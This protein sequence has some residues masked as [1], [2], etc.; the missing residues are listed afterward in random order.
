MFNK[1][2]N[3]DINHFSLNDCLS[4]LD[5]SESF[6]LSM[7]SLYYEPNELK[8]AIMTLKIKHKY[9]ALHINIQSLPAT[10]DKLKDLL[11]DLKIA[12]LT[13]DLVLLCETFLTDNTSKNFQIDGYNLVT[14]NQPL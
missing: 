13:F 3:I 5:S 2:E 7:D 8:E 12:G 9:N 4:N 6:Q 11:S 10:F 14:Q 1:G